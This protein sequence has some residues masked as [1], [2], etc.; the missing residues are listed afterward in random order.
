MLMIRFQRIGRKNDPAFRMAVLEKTA[1]PKAGKYVDLVGTYNPKTKAMTV[2]GDRIK[3]WVAKGAQL[4]PSLSNLLV[5]KGIIE[6]K[7]VNVLPK[8][9]PIVKEAPAEEA[10]P[11]APAVAA[12]EAEVAAPEEA[13]E[14]AVAEESA[15]AEEAPAEAPA[16]AEEKAAA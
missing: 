1:G 4:S 15:P 6:G 14:A 16:E 10:A 7:K 3:E 13:P 8:K 5:S 12:E 9:T 11:A 2:N